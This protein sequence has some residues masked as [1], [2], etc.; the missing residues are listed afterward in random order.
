[1]FAYAVLLHFTRDESQA[2]CKKIYEALNIGGLFVLSV[3]E[4]SGDKIDNK[5]LG[6]KRYFTFWQMEELE[7]ML[8]TAGFKITHSARVQS[9][10]EN[11]P[12]WL[13]AIAQKS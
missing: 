7:K 10:R 6:Q 8:T 4:G 11:G 13:Q 3:K 12:V 5:K 9:R 2:V 1:M